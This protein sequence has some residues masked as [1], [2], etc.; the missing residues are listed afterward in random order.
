MLKSVIVLCRCQFYMF[1][2]VFLT[3]HRAALTF[4]LFSEVGTFGGVATAWNLHV[5]GGDVQKEGVR[6]HQLG[7]AC[8]ALVQYRRW[9][10]RASLL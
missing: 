4:L 10:R 6:P 9:R 2:R 8:A 5:I 3:V 1:Q 7:G